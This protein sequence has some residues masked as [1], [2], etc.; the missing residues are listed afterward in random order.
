MIL[1]LT[2][3]LL[4]LNNKIYMISFVFNFLERL[5]FFGTSFVF[6]LVFKLFAAVLVAP[7]D[8]TF[9]D[10]VALTTNQNRLSNFSQK[11]FLS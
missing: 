1:C 6:C 9:V 10:I 11:I 7:F 2:L 8:G 4:C 5:F 3:N